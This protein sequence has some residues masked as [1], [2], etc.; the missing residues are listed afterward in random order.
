MDIDEQNYLDKRDIRVRM[1]AQHDVRC[2][3]GH[4]PAMLA[5]LP[6]LLTLWWPTLLRDLH[7]GTYLG[8]PGAVPDPG[9][10][11][12]LERRAAAQN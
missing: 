6:E 7:D 2:V 4:N 8:R 1:A 5:M 11:V 12:E 3:I 10:A 9:R